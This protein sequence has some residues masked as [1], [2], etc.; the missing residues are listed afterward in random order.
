M[1]NKGNRRTVQIVWFRMMAIRF[2]LRLQNSGEN[3][4]DIFVL[5]IVLLSIDSNLDQRD[6]EGSVDL[7]TIDSTRSM[8]LNLVVM[9]D[10]VL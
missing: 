3:Q 1:N 10:N 4:K 8:C 7:K 6:G 2:K 9:K 5:V